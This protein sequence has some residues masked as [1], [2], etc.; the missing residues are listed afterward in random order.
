MVSVAHVMGMCPVERIARARVGLSGGLARAAP[1]LF[2]VLARRI[3][4]VVVIGIASYHA[5]VMGT[6]AACVAGAAAR[7][8]CSLVAARMALIAERAALTT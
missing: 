8:G 5:P 7:E 4:V 2:V 1:P 6:V 3:P